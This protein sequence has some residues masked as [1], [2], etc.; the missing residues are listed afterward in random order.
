MF[1]NQP[2]QQNLLHMHNYVIIV[3]LKSWHQKLVQVTQ[4]H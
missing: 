2:N 3:V 4:C 1:Y